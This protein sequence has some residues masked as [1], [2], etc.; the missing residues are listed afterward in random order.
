VVTRSLILIRRHYRQSILGGTTGARG[1]SFSGGYP[2]TSGRA[3]HQ[4][5]ASYPNAGA[6]AGLAQAVDARLGV[7][8]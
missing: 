6:A 5:R 4:P 7:P 3:A 2:A 1:R 8:A